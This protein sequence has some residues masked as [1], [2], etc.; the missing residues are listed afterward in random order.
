MY[1]FKNAFLQQPL[2]L[3]AVDG[4]SRKTVDLPAKNPIRF[5]FF[6]T[7]QHFFENWAVVRCLGRPSFRKHF[8]NLQP[9]PIRQLNKTLLL[10]VDALYLPFFT[11]GTFAAVHE[12]F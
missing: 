4:V 5:T 6:N 3:S 10:V 1:G 11:F 12:V 2:D 9:K 7:F 8:H